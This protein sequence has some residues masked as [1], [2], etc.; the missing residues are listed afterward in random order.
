MVMKK[1]SKIEIVV[2][3]CVLCVMATMAFAGMGTV[4]ITSAE[5]SVLA[6][7]D[8][9]RWVVLQNNSTNDI[10]VKVD[11]STTALT[12]NNGIKLAASGG[13]LTITDNG[14]ANPAANAV[15]AIVS[16]GTSTL[17]F[18]EGNEF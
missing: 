10:W 13:T 18:S 15:K 14:Q 3:L 17:T 12:A 8:R 5:T 9:R 7:N 16:S 4:S 6:A 11:S 1:T 2:T